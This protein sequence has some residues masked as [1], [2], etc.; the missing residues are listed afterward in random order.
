MSV[1]ADYIYSRGRDEKFIQDNVNLSFT[2]ASGIGINNPYTNRALLPYPQ[3]GIVAMTP[4][5]GTSA[6]HALQTA[7]T[8]R[9][10]NNWQAGAT[11]SLAGLWSAEG[12]PFM[13]VPGREPGPVPFPVAEDLG[14][15]GGWTY[16]LSDQRHRA[17]F[18]G[19]WQ[20][21]RGFQVSGLHYWGAG[22]RASSNYG[23]D[24]RNLGAGGEAAGCA[25]TAR[26][27]RRTRFIQPPQNAPTSGCSSGFRAGGVS[28][29]L[30]AEAF[31]VFN[32]PNWTLETQESSADYGK[33][34]AAQYRSA[35]FG[36]RMVFLT[37]EG[38]RGKG[39][40]GRAV[41][42]NRRLIPKT[43]LAPFPLA[44]FP[45][46]AHSSSCRFFQRRQRS[47]P[48]RL[49]TSNLPS[50]SLRED[51]LP[52]EFPGVNPRRQKRSGPIGSPGAT[53]RFVRGCEGG[54]EDS[55]IHLLLFGT[56]FT[57]APR[58]SERDLAALVTAPAEGLRALRARIDDSPRRS[59]RREAT[60]GCSL[61]GSRSSGKGSI[62]TS[63]R[64]SC[65][66]TSRS[67]RRPSA[68]PCALPRCS[69]RRPDSRGS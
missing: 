40:E 7:F 15:P 24:R 65:A 31:N 28:I 45:L 2:N 39:L 1:E 55:I 25:R 13:G 66:A 20:V 46:I 10:S 29:D 17:V 48:P 62:R 43:A 33:R 49:P 56:T 68:A 50:K 19:I 9:L 3:F 37:R 51:F 67:G 52:A 63:G 32:R 16:A 61:R 21:G 26:S 30:I 27:S 64:G 57:K 53:R 34:V 60:S 12:Q 18:N 58:A 54:E 35:Q 11:Y 41:S 47:G 59:R 22:N 42:G 14:G 5:T 4:F 6:Y 44:P 38:G 23:G 36:F 8:K 69:I